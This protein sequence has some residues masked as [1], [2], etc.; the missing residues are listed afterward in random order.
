V[1]TKYVDKRPTA[2]F[3]VG[4][5]LVDVDRRDEAG[6]LQSCLEAEYFTSTIQN[7]IQTGQS[8]VRDR[9]LEALELQVPPDYVG[10]QHLLIEHAAAGPPDASRTAKKLL[11]HLGLEASEVERRSRRREHAVRSRLFGVDKDWLCEI[12]YDATA[13]ARSAV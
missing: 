11:R 13:L 1:D 2:R 3:E 4:F 5:G 9:D 7:L 10:V 8:S 12:H 6:E